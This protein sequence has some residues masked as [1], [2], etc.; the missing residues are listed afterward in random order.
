MVGLETSF[1]VCYTTLVIPG[2]ITLGRLTE[3]MSRNPARILN[4]NKGCIA[5]GCFGDLVLVDLVT[6]WTVDASALASKGRNTPFAGKTLFGRTVMTIKAGRI[7][8]DDTTSN[9][10]ERQ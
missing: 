1:G 7:V 5:P 2:H 8:Y 9:Q 3:L 4:V 6:P 10:E